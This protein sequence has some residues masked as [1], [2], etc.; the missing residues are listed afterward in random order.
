MTLWGWWSLR[1][2]TS[3]LTWVF[4]V[5]HMTYIY[6]SFNR[7][8]SFQCSFSCKWKWLP[9]NLAV[10][11]ILL[12][13]YDCKCW[14]GQKEPSRFFMATCVSSHANETI[15]INDQS[16]HHVLIPHY[17]MVPRD[18]ETTDCQKFITSYIPNFILKMSPNTQIL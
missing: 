9:N 12:Y 4:L 5:S 7:L 3:I 8:I 13:M 15:C 2:E 17:V 16:K 11:E 10:E 14:L 18:T 1:T 6:T